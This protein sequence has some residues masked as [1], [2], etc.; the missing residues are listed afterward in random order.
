M[1]IDKI[2][3]GKYIRLLRQNNNLQT[4][5]FSTL[6]AIEAKLMSRIERR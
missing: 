5:E 1:A 4:K 6:C 2:K 3:I